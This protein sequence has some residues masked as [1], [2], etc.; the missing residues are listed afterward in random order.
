MKHVAKQKGFADAKHVPAFINSIQVACAHDTPDTLV[1]KECAK[2]RLVTGPERFPAWSL[3]H[4]FA[5]P[6]RSAGD[7]NTSD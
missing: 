7:L 5:S 6:F 1:T 3:S 4:R 2:V